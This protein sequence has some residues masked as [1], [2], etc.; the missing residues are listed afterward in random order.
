MSLHTNFLFCRLVRKAHIGRSLLVCAAFTRRFCRVFWKRDCS[1]DFCVPNQRYSAALIQTLGNNKFT[2]KRTLLYHAG[3]CEPW[4]NNSQNSAHNFTDVPEGPQTWH[5]SRTN[6]DQVS[7]AKMS[8]FVNKYQIDKKTTWGT[9]SQVRSWSFDICSWCLHKKTDA[10]RRHCRCQTSPTNS[11]QKLQSGKQNVCAQNV[12]PL[13]LGHAHVEPTCSYSFLA[14]SCSCIL[15]SI[16]FICLK[17]SSLLIWWSPSLSA[18][19]RKFWKETQ[20]FVVRIFLC[21]CRNLIHV[22]RVGERV[23][24]IVFWHTYNFV[25]TM[26]L[27]FLTTKFSQIMAR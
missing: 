2:T 10:I 7:W 20:S 16:L 13:T 22:A 1:G 25:E 8:H 12:P 27:P 17:N 21:F 26:K 9:N 19:A 5:D 4:Q 6:F 23:G 11:H 18:S 14:F 24:C 15:M 3:L